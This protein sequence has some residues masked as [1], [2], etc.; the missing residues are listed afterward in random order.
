MRGAGA[1]AFGRWFRS[2]A[3]TCEAGRFWEDPQPVFVRILPE[4]LCLDAAEPSS[5]TGSVPG[6]GGL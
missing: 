5:V 4:R 1:Q 3:S 6:G 2:S